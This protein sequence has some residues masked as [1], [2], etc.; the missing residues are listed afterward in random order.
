MRIFLPLIV[1]FSLTG[2]AGQTS[3]VAYKFANKARYDAVS[4]RLNLYAATQPAVEQR[5][6]SDLVKSWKIEVDAQQA[7]P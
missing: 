2:C 6:V 1:L 5:T 7:N 4:P 3:P